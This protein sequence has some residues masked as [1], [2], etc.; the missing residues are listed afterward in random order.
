MTQNPSKRPQEIEAI[1]S[2]HLRVKLP[3]KF[4]AANTKSSMA[5]LERGT[6][7]GP[8]EKPV[9]FFRGFDFA[10]KP[11]SKFQMT[12]IPN[13]EDQPKIDQAIRDA[14]GASHNYGGSLLQDKKFI[15][16]EFMRRLDSFKHLPPHSG[17]NILHI[18]AGNS[19]FIVHVVRA[20]LRT[21]GTER[22][23][24][25]GV[26]EVA[27]RGLFAAPPQIIRQTDKLLR[28]EWGALYHG[29]ED[30]S[31]W[32]LPEGSKLFRK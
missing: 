4:R 24:L 7:K 19:R 14:L 13:A 32:K 9:Y 28:K 1:G 6:V 22:L 31:G 2:D 10:V 21:G 25:A 26:Y 8:D 18:N 29:V 23:T 17:N 11:D 15:E 16:D 30:T 3:E 12:L 27:Q 5:I 20:R